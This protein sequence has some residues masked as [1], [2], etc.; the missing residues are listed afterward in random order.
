MINSIQCPYRDRDRDRDR[1]QTETETERD[2][3]RDRDRDRNR[4]IGTKSHDRYFL[5]C[6]I[7]CLPRARHE[8]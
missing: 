6:R 3:D 4:N 8:I 1:L 5:V 7:E 2:K